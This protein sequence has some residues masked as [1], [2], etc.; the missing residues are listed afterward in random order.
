[1]A[2]IVGIKRGLARFQ[3][4]IERIIKKEIEMGGG[5]GLP[6]EQILKIDKYN[7]FLR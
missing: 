7:K 5:M 1:M 3:N 6:K 2:Y 4:I